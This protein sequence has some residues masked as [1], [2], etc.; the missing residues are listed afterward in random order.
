VC[1][2]RAPRRHLA[3]SCHLEMDLARINAAHGPSFRGVFITVARPAARRPPR[4][5]RD[6]VAR[7]RALKGSA[8]R[9]WLASA[10]YHPGR[11]SRGLANTDAE[12]RPPGTIHHHEACGRP[13]SVTP[14]APAPCSSGVISAYRMCALSRPQGAYSLPRESHGGSRTGVVHSGREGSQTGGCVVDC[15]ECALH[16]PLSLDWTVS[17]PRRACDVTELAPKRTGGC[18]GVAST[19]PVGRGG[20]WRS[21]S[22][23]PGI[24]TAGLATHS[25][26]GSSLHKDR[27]ASV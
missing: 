26:G 25:R 15:I 19:G 3:R 23:Q 18:F 2:S 7:A 11:C 9:R 4:L 22:S 12:P 24:A 27:I 17:L 13:P 20:G 14:S 10:R 16:G 6:A 21:C 5:Q 1:S 8:F